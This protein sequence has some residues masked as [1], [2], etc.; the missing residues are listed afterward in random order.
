[1]VNHG[2][3]VFSPEQDGR[4]HIQHQNVSDREIDERASDQIG[5]RW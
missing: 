4:K 1:M 3:S 5:S 2:V